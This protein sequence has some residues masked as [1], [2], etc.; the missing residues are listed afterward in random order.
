MTIRLVETMVACAEGKKGLK[1]GRSHR[2]LQ[3]REG[4]AA[5][6]HV[7]GYKRKFPKAKD[8][9]VDEEKR[10]WTVEISSRAM[11]PLR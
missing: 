9:H 4:Q 5:D 1:E 2:C 11:L 6:F 8:Y 7:G 10:L 3:G